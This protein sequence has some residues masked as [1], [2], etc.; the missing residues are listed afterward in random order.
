LHKLNAIA[1]HP[2]QKLKKQPHGKIEMYLDHYNL[3]E[4]PFSISPDPRFLWFGETHKEALASLKYG[5]L[6]SKGF[7]LLTGNIGTGKTALIKALV[8][9]IDVTAI[10]ATIPDPGLES[11]DFFNFL[12]EEFKMNRRF[13]S[14]GAFLINLKKFLHKA[15]QDNK[16]VLLI[17][18]EAQRLDHD[19]LEQI[20]LLSNIEMDNR[21]LINIFF[22]GQIEFNDMLNDARNRAVRQR[23]GVSY[24][25]N[26]L[27]EDENIQYIHHRLEVAGGSND[28]FSSGAVRRIYAYSQGNPRVTNIICDHALLT[29]YTAGRKTID[30]NII[31][32]CGNE[33]NIA[34]SAKISKKSATVPEDIP[35]IQASEKKYQKKQLGLIFVFLLIL[36][37]A[38][39]FFYDQQI[40]DKPRW[41][42]E[43]IAPKKDPT[44]S[45]KQKESFLAQGLDR[46]QEEESHAVAET[47]QTIQK[48][49]N[50]TEAKPAAA[51]VPKE[52]P[53]IANFTQAN[54]DRKTIIHFEHNSNDLPDQAFEKLNEI[55]RYAFQNPQSQILI[56]GYTDSHGNYWYNKKLS[57]FRADIIKSYF[58][59]H[60]IPSSRLKSLGL[61]P[62]NPLASNDTFEGR[63]K[64]RRVEITIDIQR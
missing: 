4:K 30:E 61:G 7:L 57:K 18:D 36:C 10:V 34:A 41:A 17:I 53:L 25:L 46:K 56:E 21:K 55:V 48:D 26:N 11:L 1:S 16:K 5:I 28:I 64:N 49:E 43:D 50:T 14:K 33:L 37:L 24:H 39:Y 59:G 12:A 51:V 38:G 42:L 13:S 27:T 3:R 63:K 19:L 54:L 15:Y 20:R 62:D 45:A 32:E 9:I 52:L 6:E 31:D 29:G 35:V 60:G 2:I 44:F 23:I 8:K 58:T 47:T 40:D 22:V